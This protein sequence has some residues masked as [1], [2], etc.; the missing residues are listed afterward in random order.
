MAY[1][2]SSSA[3]PATV[4]V[5][6]EPHHHL[7][8]KNDYVEVLHVKLAPGESTLN[9]T[10]PH[11]GAAVQLT[12][13]TIAQQKPGEAEGPK[14]ATR[15]GDVSARTVDLPFT[16]IVHNVG[17]TEFEVLDVEFLQ[18]P[19]VPSSALAGQVAAE[20]PSARVYRWKLAPGEASPQHSHVRP[21]LIVSPV[22]MQLKM[23]A[24][25]GRSITEEVKAGDF[26]WVDAKV[27]H[28]LANAGTEPGEIVE[29]ELK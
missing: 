10:H 8:L 29:I 3:P 14:N 12:D 9:H 26:H 11:D 6:Q 4:L 7:V 17:E 18:R 23:T 27:T 21:Y 13:A 5:T 1:V 25:D 15:P 19:K 16:H 28:S 22:A 20:N 24:P 2:G